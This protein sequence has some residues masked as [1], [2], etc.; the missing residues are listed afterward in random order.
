M[1][2][3]FQSF[4][5]FPQATTNRCFLE[6]CKFFGSEFFREIVT[7]L[8]CRPL[9][10]LLL[11][12]LLVLH[13]LHGHRGSEGIRILLE[14]LLLFLLLLVCSSS[15]SSVWS[16][17]G[18]WSIVEELEQV[19]FCGLRLL[20]RSRCRGMFGGNL[21]LVRSRWRCRWFLYSGSLLGLGLHF[22]LFLLLFF[23]L[24]AEKCFS[25][26]IC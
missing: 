17:A 7:A 18:R 1:F 19:C 4:F 21:N 8:E 24:F 5:F 6:F 16:G 12:L 14:L 25:K 11:V 3:S 20:S 10:L 26:E 13:L 22:L 2:L 23:F 9:L 15:S